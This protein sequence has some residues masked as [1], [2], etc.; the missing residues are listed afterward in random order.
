MGK[1][2]NFKPKN[3]PTMSKQYLSLITIMVCSFIGAGFVSGAEIYEFFARFKWASIF[4][5]IVFFL[6]SFLL[7]YKI[8]IS[9]SNHTKTSNNSSCFKNKNLN[10]KMYYNKKITQKNTFLIKNNLKN[11]I[12]VL[13]CFFIACAMVAG[14]KNLIFQFY[15]NNYIFIFF[16]CLLV[17]FLTCYIGVRGLEKIDIFV[18][19]FVGF[20]C[21]CFCFDDSFGL[22]T[23]IQTE[24]LS[25]NSTLKFNA[26]LNSMFFAS[27][28][29]FMNIMQFEPIVEASGIIFTK[30]KSLIFALTFALMLTFPLLLF[31][32]F[33]IFNQSFTNASMPFL[34]FF[35]LRGG[36]M[37]QIFSFGLLICLLTTLITCLIGLKNKFTI[38]Y[39]TSNFIATSLGMLGVL[40]VS[41]LPFNFFVGIIYPILGFMNFIVFVFL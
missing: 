38:K 28:Y 33:L 24:T 39:Q 6:L 1:Q 2:Y 29:I 37:A 36:V 31:V 35:M 12:V 16:V 26:V 41:I 21:I 25:L 10:L 34:N 20:I 32:L 17:S 18:L 5:I 30:R 7:C 14:L 13:N 22:I 9:S 11:I 19:V 40:V 3:T 4:G 27:L 15:N 23:K 8:L